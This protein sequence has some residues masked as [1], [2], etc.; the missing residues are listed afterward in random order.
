MARFWKYEGVYVG[1]VKESA[2]IVSKIV[3]VPVVPKASVAVIVTVVWERGVVGIPDNM[4]VFA[5]N[6]SPYV[7]SEI[8]LEYVIGVEPDVD[9]A[10]KAP[11]VV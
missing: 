9:V 1:H 3:V 7:A 8:E 4:P 2:R 11:G 5:F 10:E 6:V